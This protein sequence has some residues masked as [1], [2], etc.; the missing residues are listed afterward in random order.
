EAT[1][2]VEA[3]PREPTTRTMKRVDLVR[4]P[5]T[6]GDPL[7]AIEV[8]PGVAQSTGD[9]PIIR[10]AAG[11]S[12]VVMLDGSQVPF[13]YH[14]GGLT[15]FVHPRLVEQVDLYPGNFSARYGR[16]TGGIVE[17]RLRKPKREF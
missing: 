16:A 7:R 17:A 8:L 3:P 15:S 12:S 13:L 10:G 4:M 14:F 1:A 5:G 6:R 9:L 2:E 11:N